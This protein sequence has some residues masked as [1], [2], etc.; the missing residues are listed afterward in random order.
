[1]SEMI[2]EFLIEQNFMTL[3]KG[4][5]GGGA[6]QNDLAEYFEKYSIQKKNLPKTSY[7]QHSLS[8]NSKSMY[9]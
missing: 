4:E 6:N 5:A 1:M 9:P 2:D 7:R 3:E 8:M